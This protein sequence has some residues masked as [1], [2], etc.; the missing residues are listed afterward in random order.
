MASKAQKGGIAATAIAMI[1]GVIAVEGGYVDHPN[2]PGGKTNMGITEQV[3]RQEGYTGP[4][5][6]L[7][8]SVAESVYYHRYL[9]APGYAPL[10]AIDAAVTEELFDTTVNM[11]PARPSR[12]FQQA[13]N[14]QC[15]ARLVVDGKV[16][17]ATIR[18]YSGCQITYGKT[19]LCITMLDRL[20]AKQSAEY[21]RLARVNPRLR[22]FLKGWQA[23]R[24]G[25]VDR[26]KCE[27]GI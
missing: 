6:T 16:G 2:D 10:I 9:V 18:A 19:R 5:R 4:M 8:R 24:V 21:D 25:N 3:A 26:A 17:S 27:A 11:G 7:P 20:D 12:W 1:A 13:I 22:V 15:S 14:E 23:H